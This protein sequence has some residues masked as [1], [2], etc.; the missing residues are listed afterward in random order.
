MVKL[1]IIAALATVT[2]LLNPAGK[3]CTGFGFQEVVYSYKQTGT[4]PP[5]VNESSSLTY[6]SAK[7]LFYTNNDSGGKPVVFEIDKRVH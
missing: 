3:D 4:M 2:S 7:D 1:S 5:Q 6:G